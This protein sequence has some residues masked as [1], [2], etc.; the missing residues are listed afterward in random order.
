MN[1]VDNTLIDSMTQRINP[2][3]AS[4][5]LPPAS[6]PA[7]NMHLPRESPPHTTLS[8]DLPAPPVYI[9]QEA[10][11]NQPQSS[12]PTNSYASVYAPV[13]PAPTLPRAS[14]A[15][16]TVLQQ[17]VVKFKWQVT[18]FF[19]EDNLITSIISFDTA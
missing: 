10:G 3:V 18:F 16:S 12:A 5:F 9:K 17:G 1:V 14:A 11:H 2:A 4:H 7:K 13:P 19:N 8:T 15:A 6:S